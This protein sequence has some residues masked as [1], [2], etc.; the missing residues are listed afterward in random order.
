MR[1]LRRLASVGLL[2][3][4]LGLLG[5]GAQAGAQPFPPIPGPIPSPIPD[6]IGGAGGVFP[7]IGRAHV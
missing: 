3:I 2:V 5:G 1:T 6:P 4:V 7:K